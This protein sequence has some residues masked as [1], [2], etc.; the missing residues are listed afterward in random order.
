MEP[1]V[2]RI[3]TGFYR[4]E[5]FERAVGS[6]YGKYVATFESDHQQ[7]RAVLF[8]DSGM[9]VAHLSFAPGYDGGRATDRYLGPLK[10]FARENGFEG[11]FRL[12]YS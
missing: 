5:D 9:L 1:A 3:R 6:F 11:R 10:E 2:D 12:V 7:V 4:D 8:E